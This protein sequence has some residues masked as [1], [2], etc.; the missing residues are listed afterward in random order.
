MA[1]SDQLTLTLAASA[2]AP[3]ADL[4]ITTD[5]DIAAENLIH[6]TR[7]LR[8]DPKQPEVFAETSSLI[9][10]PV[11]RSAPLMTA[12]PGPTEWAQR[13]ARPTP[14]CTT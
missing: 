5:P 7:N 3:G 13:T 8:T 10:A 12:A 6:H 11:F 2:P 4:A 14:G 9:S 1:I